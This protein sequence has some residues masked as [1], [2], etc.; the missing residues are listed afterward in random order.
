MNFSKASADPVEAVTEA[1][2]AGT[3]AAI[4]ADIRATLH[5]DVVNLVW[6][7]LATMPGALEW[8]WPALKPLYLG[9]APAA[10]EAVRRGI[11]LPAAVPFSEDALAAAGLDADALAG[12]RNVLDSYDHTNAL[13]L[14]VFSAF[15]SSVEGGGQASPPV[16][17]VPP[18]VMPRVPRRT[19][20]PRLTP[21]SEMPPWLARLV[22]ELNSFG[23]DSDTA[24]VASMYRHLAHWPSYL[25]LT[26]TLLV[27]LHLN[28]ALQRLVGATRRLGEEH[29]RRLAPSLSVSPPPAAADQAIAA[30]RRFVNHP[31]ARMTGVCALMRHATPGPAAD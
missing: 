3:T 5:V 31:I 19:A 1:D 4:F 14:V 29:G 27:P 21:I 10:A 23:E 30:V 16:V 17:A 26:R 20:L 8:V 18:A 12:I 22:D 11:A 25:A 2:A 9:A 24:L 15:L 28:G 7:H 6:R 13:A